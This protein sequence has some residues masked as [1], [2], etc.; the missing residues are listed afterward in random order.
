M[1]SPQ[2]S[3]DNAEAIWVSSAFCGEQVGF[4]TPILSA[5]QR[6]VLEQEYVAREKLKAWTQFLL[7][8]LA[9]ARFYVVQASKQSAL[10]LSSSQSIIRAPLLNDGPELCEYRHRHR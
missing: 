6:L 8:I 3:T 5:E 2:Q 4:C 1:T 7:S 9:L 10:A